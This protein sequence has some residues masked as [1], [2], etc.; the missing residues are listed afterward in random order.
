[1]TETK[2]RA[3][4]GTPYSDLEKSEALLRLAIN[5]GDIQKTSDELGITRRTLRRWANTSTNRPGI[6]QLLER[7]LD[8]ILMQVP[9]NMNGRDWAV[10]V[11]I[12]FDKWLLSRGEPTARL[13]MITNALPGV[14]PEEV[15]DV[16]AEASRLL[17][18]EIPDGYHDSAAVIN[19]ERA[20]G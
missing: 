18:A 12:L 7:A 19:K 3:R 5:K 11:G 8:R 14:S 15:E 17:N 2:P 16:M 9:E 20:S 1:M 10:A 6:T 13:E 4:K